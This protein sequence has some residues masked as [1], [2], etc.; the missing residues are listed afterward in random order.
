MLCLR[1]ADGPECGPATADVN[2]AGPLDSLGAP[3]VTP[4][5]RPNPA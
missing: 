3:A 1:S 4:P 2:R 5:F